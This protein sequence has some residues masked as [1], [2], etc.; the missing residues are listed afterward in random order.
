MTDVCPEAIALLSLQS[1]AG[2]L[3]EAISVGVFIVKI[4]SKFPMFTRTKS[5]D[6]M[7]TKCSIEIFH[8]F[9]VFQSRRKS[10]VKR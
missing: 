9:L 8:I 2:V 10:E 5:Y 1:I 7:L 3:I 4:S 6:V